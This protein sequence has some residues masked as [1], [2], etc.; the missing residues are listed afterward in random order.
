[1][2]NCPI[3][4]K[5]LLE[6]MPHESVD[7]HITG[8]QIESGNVL[9]VTLA[10]KQG[11]VGDSPKVKQHPVFFCGTK[12]KIINIGHQ[13]STTP[14]DSDVSDTKISHSDD[15]RPLCYHSG[16]AQLKRCSNL[17]TEHL[18]RLRKMG[19]CLSVRADQVDAR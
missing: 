3:S 17:F 10:R 18:L 7:D 4:V 16:I 15:A 6:E 2:R 5:W 1:M 19:D 11:D 9:Q 8:S 14:T 12:E 13:G